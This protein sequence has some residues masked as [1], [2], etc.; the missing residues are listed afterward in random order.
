MSQGSN[1]LPLADERSSYL[2]RAGFTRNHVW[3]TPYAP[4]ER[5]PAGEYPNQHAGGA[6][7]PEWTQANREVTNRQIVV[8]YTVG[9][10]HAARIEDWPVMP[11]AHAGFLLRPNGFFQQSPALNVP[12][13]VVSAHDDCCG[14]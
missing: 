9:V 6:G 4:E 11:V 8:W 10:H 7:L 14:A 5:Y 12:P 2:Q 1:V 3:V 13:P